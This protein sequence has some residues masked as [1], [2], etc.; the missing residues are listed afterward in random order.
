MYLKIHEFYRVLGLRSDWFGNMAN[1]FGI[2]TRFSGRSTRWENKGKKCGL[3]VW[4]LNVRH[5]F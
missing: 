3:G 2:Q 5:E 1:V 4:Y